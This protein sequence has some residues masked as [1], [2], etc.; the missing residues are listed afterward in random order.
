MTSPACSELRAAAPPALERFFEAMSALLELRSRPERLEAELGSSPSGTK[1]LGF[2]EVLARRNRFIALRQLCPATRHAALTHAPDLW[3]EIVTQ[4]ARAHP[5]ADA[6]PNRF[7]AG[8]SDFL[9]EWR[10]ADPSLPAYLEELADFEFC[11]WEVGVHPFVPSFDDPGLDRTLC[12][13]QYDF[14][15]PA[16]VSAF[17]QGS[18]P[19]SPAPR[20]CTVIIYRDVRSQWPRTFYATP[21]GLAAIARRS[22]RPLH[23]P[24]AALV[25]LDEAETQLEREGMLP[26]LDQSTRAR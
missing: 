21:L 22:Q 18:A 24:H 25:G 17:H 8:L 2:Y 6:D 15:L 3:S 1:R 13:R 14:D 20:P 11:T 4:Y 23:G 16:Y 10:A 19:S 5:P 26:E 9:A 12:V 7:A